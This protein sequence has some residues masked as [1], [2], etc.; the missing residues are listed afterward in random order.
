MEDVESVIIPFLDDMIAKEQE[1]VSTSKNTTEVA[2][3]R[4]K[5]AQL[6]QAK[7]GWQGLLDRNAKLYQDAREGKLNKTAVTHLVADALLQDEKGDNVKYINGTQAPNADPLREISAIRY[8]IDFVVSFVTMLIALWHSFGG[9]GA[10]IAY[11]DNLD[12]ERAN[13]MSS[14]ELFSTEVGIQAQGNLIFTT[15][16]FMFGTSLGYAGEREKYS[17]IESGVADARNRG[18]S[19]ADPDD[20]DY[21]DVQVSC[22]CVGY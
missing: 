17:S 7:N 11:S 6:T 4:N 18:F 16:G 5:T 12:T 10:K 8:G 19:L 22:T 3:S 20:G 9:A 1:T 2:V 21:F 13:T 14:G 15:I